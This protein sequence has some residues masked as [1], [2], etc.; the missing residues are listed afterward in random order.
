MG[1]N[2][3]GRS[4]LT[5]LDYTPQV[6]DELHKVIFVVP[7]LDGSMIVCDVFNDNITFLDNEYLYHGFLEKIRLSQ[8]L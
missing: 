1:I 2:I 7:A 8:L 6:M 3:R 5:L 4:F